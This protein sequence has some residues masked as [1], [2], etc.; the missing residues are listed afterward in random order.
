NVR[1]WLVNK[2][3]LL[4]AEGEIENIVTVALDIGERK[5]GELEMRKAKDAAEAALRNLRETQNSLIEAEKLAALGRLVAGVAAEVHNP[6]GI[7]PAGPPALERKKANFT[8]EVARGE[9]RR[10]S[11]NDFLDTSRDA[12]S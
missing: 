12:S 10:S 3:P 9:L 7:R 5:R 8:A 2:L 4:Y 11:L 1:Q 6:V